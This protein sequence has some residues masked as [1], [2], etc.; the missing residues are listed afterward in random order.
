MKNFVFLAFPLLLAPTSSNTLPASS[1]KFR[2]A[3]QITI[4]TPVDHDLYVAGERIVINAPVRGDMLAAAGT[5]TVLDSIQGDL[6]A[7][8]GT[9][10]L[11]APVL[12][13][14]L[15]MGGTMQ[16]ESLVQG[17]IIAM[18]GEVLINKNAQAGQDV[19]VLSGEVQLDGTVAGNVIVYGGE[20]QL[21]GECQGNLQVRGGEI[22][23]NGTVQGESTLTADQ[24]TL[25][26]EAQLYGNVRYW[27]PEDAEPPNFAAVLTGAT[28][29][30]DAS[31]QPEGE[32][33]WLGSSIP[34]FSIGLA[35]V[36]AVLLIIGFIFWV[37]P[38][39][40][41][42]AGKVLHEDFM[43]SFGYGAL[44]LVGVP[45][46]VALLFL[47]VIG[48]PLGLFFL[49]AY[50]FTIMF[51]HIITSV[52]VTYSL[53]DRYQYQWGNGWMILV[54]FLVFSVLR[55]LTLTPLVGLFISALMVG[56]CLGALMIPV[57]RRKQ[58][59]AA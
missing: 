50:F 46:G 31:L 3:E 51:G 21:N 55:M 53:R 37:F 39:A 6:T 10:T 41:D 11:N 52:V 19:V 47:T 30:F 43:R 12:D 34:W 26:P 59:I 45:L 27:L 22:T 18:G 48:I 54:A 32:F 2:A 35:Y 13:D 20:V 42:R 8:G 58:P 16:I 29:Q 7:A 40:M 44:Y 14:V 28:V 33:S 36:L 15:A 24:I 9:I 23:I 5:I 25:D 4:D 57:V 38:R 1:E 49:S 56:A 17:D